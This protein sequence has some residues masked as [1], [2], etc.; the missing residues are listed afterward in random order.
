MLS[1]EV[2][3]KLSESEAVDRIKNFFARGYGLEIKDESESCLTLVGGGGYVRAN[4]CQ[5]QG[6]TRIDFETREWE[7]QVKALAE[8]LG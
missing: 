2:R 6:K 1:L 5:E 7:G 3:T 8:D 4:L